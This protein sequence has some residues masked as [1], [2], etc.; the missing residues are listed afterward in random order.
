MVH[1]TLGRVGLSAA[2]VDIREFDKLEVRR[3]VVRRIGFQPVRELTWTIERN[4][5]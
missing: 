4:V 2:S 5:T 3:H 1:K